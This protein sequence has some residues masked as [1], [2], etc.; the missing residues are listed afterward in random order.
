MADF[1]YYTLQ[2]GFL[3]RYIFQVSDF[4]VG[5][6]YSAHCTGTLNGHEYRANDF[7]GH[8]DKTEARKLWK[9][10]TSNGWKLQPNGHIF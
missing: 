3:N 1:T 4:G 7:L 10:L 9:S 5:V 2:N 8:Y 6:S